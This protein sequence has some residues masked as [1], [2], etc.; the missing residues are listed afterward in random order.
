MAQKLEFEMAI[1]F[2]VDICSKYYGP[3]SF[4]HG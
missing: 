3:V 1:T 2:D 4:L